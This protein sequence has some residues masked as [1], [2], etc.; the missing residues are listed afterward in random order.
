MDIWRIWQWI[1]GREGTRKKGITFIEHP[2]GT[3]YRV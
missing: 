2:L 1:Q 3:R